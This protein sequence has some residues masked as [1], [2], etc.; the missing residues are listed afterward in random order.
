MRIIVINLRKVERRRSSGGLLSR[1]L[2][3]GL[4]ALAHYGW[5]FGRRAHA[6]SRGLA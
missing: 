3:F 6:T 5:D 1:A 2:S 4:E